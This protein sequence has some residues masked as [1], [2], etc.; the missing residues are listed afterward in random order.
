MD[1]LWQFLLIIM[2]F[3]VIPVNVSFDKSGLYSIAVSLFPNK[4]TVLLSN[5]NVAIWQAIIKSGRAQPP[6]QP[7]QDRPQLQHQSDQAKVIINFFDGLN[8]SDITSVVSIPDICLFFSTSTIFGS[9]F[10]HTKG[11]KLR[12][13]RFCD[14]TA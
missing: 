12:Q 8:W 11:R 5:F 6:P 4:E 10:L 3:L 14:K 1:L 9:I 13:N 2:W 7:L